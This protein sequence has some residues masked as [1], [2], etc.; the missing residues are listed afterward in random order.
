MTYSA[1]EGETSN[2]RA[3]SADGG[4]MHRQV[5]LLHDQSGSSSPEFQ[6]ALPG[7]GSRGRPGEE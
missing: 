6:A 5:E 4:Y 1:S 7:G 2:T 3:G